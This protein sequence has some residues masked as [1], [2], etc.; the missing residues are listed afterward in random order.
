MTRVVFNHRHALMTLAAVAVSGCTDA[1]T[2]SAPRDPRAST[3]SLQITGSPS[4]DVSEFQ[5]ALIASGFDGH[6][7]IGSDVNDADR[8]AG[9]ATVAGGY[10]HG[11]FWEHGRVTDVGTLGGLNSQSGGRAARAELA[12]MSELAGTDPL[13]E[14]FCGFH[15]GL[16]C[17]AAV[18]S[19]GALTLLPTLGGINAAA[20]QINA[21]GEVVGTSEENSVVDATCIPPQKTRFQAVVWDQAGKIQKLAP[22]AGDEVSFATRNNDRGQVVGSS[23]LCAN[24]VLGG[25]PLGPHAVLWD[26]GSP[27]IHLGSLAGD[28]ADVGVAADINNRGE[29]IGGSGTSSQSIHAFLWTRATGMR[30]LGPGLQN[31]GRADAVNAPFEI[32]N[33]GQF[34]GVS[35]RDLTMSDCA[36]YLWRD[37]VMTDLNDLIPE[38][39]PLYLLLPFGINDQ[40]DITGLAI[41]KAT[42]A[43]R[44]F[45]ATPAR[46]SGVSRATGAARRTMLHMGLPESARALLRSRFGISR[47]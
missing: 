15:T 14:D 27:P 35:C 21:R 47:R 26:N 10:Q 42:G 40:G 17:R 9:G 39:S 2:T 12:I 19:R 28:D 37:G 8:V 31:H 4:Y 32:N 5:S 6:F 41:D 22:L 38:D 20:V 18:W 16:V 29:V 46:A 3:M 13:G 34:V 30:D 44:A 1:L 24:T 11:F 25:L 7:S 36:A 33:E 45:L 43:P 23:G